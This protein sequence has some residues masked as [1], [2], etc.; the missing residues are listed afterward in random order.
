MSDHEDTRQAAHA[1]KTTSGCEGEISGQ[2]FPL[3]VGH[4]M[5]QRQAAL[6]LYRR[7]L[8]VAQRWEAPAEQG[9]IRQEARAVAELGRT[10]AG[11]SKEA[12]SMLAAAESRLTIAVHYKIPYPRPF[13]VPPRTT[14][15]GPAATNNNAVPQH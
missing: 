9:Y 12:D 7:A 2:H 6:G 1:T 14:G 5:S 8:R 4:V 15:L 13:N 3:A 10:V 11:G